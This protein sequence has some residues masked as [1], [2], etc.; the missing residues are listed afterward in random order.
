VRLPRTQKG[1]DL[2][3]LDAAVLGLLFLFLLAVVLGGPIRY[4]AVQRHL[5]WLPYLPHFLLAL[6][7]LPM[8]FAYLVREGVTSTFL[9]IL[10]LFG[11]AITWGALNLASPG[12]VEF[13]LWVLLPFLYGV[14][15]LPAILRGWRKLVPYAF[16]LWGV[17][18][19]GV[20]VNVFREYPWVG[21]EYQVG[22]TTIEASRLWRLG[23]L[24]LIRLCGFG[25]APGDTAI[26][27]L[28]PALFL[29]E[30][31]RGRWKLAIWLLSGVAV[32]LTTHK[33]SIVVFLLFSALWFFYRGSI[34]S[35]WRLIP[36]LA[37]IFDTFLPFWGAFGQTGWV[38]PAQSLAMG[39]ATNTFY[40]RLKLGWPETLRMIIE[41]GNAVLGRGLGGIGAPQL[42][43]EPA[44]ARPADNAIVFLYGSFGLL[45]IAFL[46]MYAWRASRLRDASPVA[47]FFFF[48][49]CFLL[50]EG[51]MVDAMEI[52]FAGWALGASFRYL[53][54]SR[55]L[56]R[57]PELARA[58]LRAS[59]AAGPK[60]WRQ[61]APGESPLAPG[62]P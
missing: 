19:L 21:L 10:A 29:W 25:R 30:T 38:H 44:L 57:V 7:I 41:H 17:A 49:A 43:F 12:Q 53:Q 32:G 4:F 23:G 1:P 3:P 37:V 13:G 60:P 31:L 5:P 42:Y 39:V 46:G 16:L 18:V 58:R 55:V 15:A 24:D 56:S 54:E 28:L 22:T 33:T 61:L 26:E 34:R 40:E 59:R 51:A 35:A 62:K 9:V 6:G 50:L 47:R 52:A 2:P 48:C 20:L 27:I 14:V 45:G 11:I 8:F 36:L